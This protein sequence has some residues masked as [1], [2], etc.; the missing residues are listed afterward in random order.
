MLL[1]EVCMHV[2]RLG[3][4]YTLHLSVIRGQQQYFP[5]H[6]RIFGF[7][8]AVCVSQFQYMCVVFLGVIQLGLSML[9]RWYRER[10]LN[11]CESLE[12]GK[13]ERTNWRSHFIRYLIHKIVSVLLFF[14]Y[15]WVCGACI[16]RIS[17]TK[18]T[19]GRKYVQHHLKPL[20]GV[21]TNY[22]YFCLP[23][24]YW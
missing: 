6:T 23:H 8:S 11:P 9:C 3:F 13:S 12:E 1:Y 21:W 15:C 17:A 10:G 24:C 16:V 22:Q 14:Y 2:L 18:F 20:V 5:T 4:V 19:Y 7:L